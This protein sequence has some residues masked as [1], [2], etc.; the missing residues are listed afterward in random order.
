MPH[1]SRLLLR[2][3]AIR[4]RA[5]EQFKKTSSG[6]KR[7]LFGLLQSGKI[8]AVFDYPSALGPQVG[9]PATFWLGIPSGQFQTKLARRSQSSNGEVSG[10]FLVRPK[11]FIG[12]Y[13]TWLETHLVANAS[14]DLTQSVT[15]EVAS[16]LAGNSERREA[17]ILEKEWDRFVRESNLDVIKHADEA[18][19]STRGKHALTSWDVVLVE[20][21]VELLARQVQGESLTQHSKIAA[22]AL[23]R[24]EKKLAN[25][26][27]APDIGTITKKIAEILGRLSEL[28]KDTTN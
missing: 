9:I 19:K 3:V 8:Q 15:K 17:Y 22:I 23:A 12:E 21:A 13:V 1:D 6:G 11:D 26:N 24:A 7:E 28:T 5:Y 27:P 16:A 20:V 25:N 2:D 18:P 10:H 14:E 4:L